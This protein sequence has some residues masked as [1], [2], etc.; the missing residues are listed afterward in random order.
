MSPLRVRHT[1]LDDDFNCCLRSATDSESDA[2]ALQYTGTGVYH[3]SRTGSF[4][5][6]DKSGGDSKIQSRG[7]LKRL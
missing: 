1:V 5:D 3:E 6:A 2:F 7:V 4:H